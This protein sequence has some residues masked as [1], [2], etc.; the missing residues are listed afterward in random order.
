MQEADQLTRE[1]MLRDEQFQAE[2]DVLAARRREEI[3]VINEQ[4]R[5]ELAQLSE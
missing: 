5:A 1:R 2:M 3:E 4:R